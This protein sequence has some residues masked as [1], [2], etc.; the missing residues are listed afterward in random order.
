MGEPPSFNSACA[1][2]AIAEAASTEQHTTL[3]NA[4]SDM[5]LI[6]R[7]KIEIGNNSRLEKK[8]VSKC[9]GDTQPNTSRPMMSEYRNLTEILEIGYVTGKHSAKEKRLAAG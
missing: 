3:A 1:D 6:L 5:R 9:G 7:K 8:A 4:C 2:V